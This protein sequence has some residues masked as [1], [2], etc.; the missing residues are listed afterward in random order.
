M[1]LSETNEFE[2]SYNAR[3]VKIRK[4]AA[5]ALKEIDR[6]RSGGRIMER[7]AFDAEV[8]RITREKLQPYGC[9][10]IVHSVGDGAP[11]FLIKVQSTGR[12]YDLIKSFFHRDDGR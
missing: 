4:A 9:D 5:I 12:E 2:A 1:N 10:L 7:E 8:A 3:V 11:R 6:L